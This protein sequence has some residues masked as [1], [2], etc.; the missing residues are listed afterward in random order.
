MEGKEDEI[1]ISHFPDRLQLELKPEKNMINV[2]VKKTSFFS[3]NKSKHNLFDSSDDY[4]DFVKLFEITKDETL[5]N[6]A[7]N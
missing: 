2:K 4:N 7:S 5:S 6:C 3:L 1:Y